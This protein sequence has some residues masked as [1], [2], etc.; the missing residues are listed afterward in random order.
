MFL[1]SISSWYYVQQLVPLKAMCS[2][3]CA[4][5]LL[6]DVSYRHPA[7]I[8]MPTVAVLDPGTVLD[9][10]CSELLSV[11]S[12]HQDRAMAPVRW[13]VGGVGGDVRLKGG[14]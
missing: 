11:L 12:S 1:I 6:C 5:L 14:R 2:R 13:I 4:T 3:N 8:H 7:L 9:T 10:T